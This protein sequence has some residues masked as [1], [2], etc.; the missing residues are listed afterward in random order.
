MLSEAFLEGTLNIPYVPA[1]LQLGE[2][3]VQENIHSHVTCAY[4]SSMLQLNYIPDAVIAGR[5]SYK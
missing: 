1:R 3:F 5:A 4:T 2:V